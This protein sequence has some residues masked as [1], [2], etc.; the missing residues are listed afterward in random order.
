MALETTRTST[1]SSSV[2]TGFFKNGDDAHKAIN[3]LLDEG[4]RTSE[5]GAVFHTTGSYDSGAGPT[6]A[7]DIRTEGSPGTVG[8]GSGISGAASDTSGVTPAGLSTGSG[9]TTAG[10][11]RPMPSG[12]LKHT[13][14]PSELSHETARSA[15]GAIPATGGLHEQPRARTGTHS[16]G[17][18]EKLKNTFSSSEPPPA[19]ESL[20]NKTSMNFGTGEGHLGAVQPEY[21]YDYSGSAFESSFSGMGVGQERSRYLASELAGGGAVITI[22]AAGKAASAE[23]V[24]ER[25]HGSVRH[26]A[27]ISGNAGW[28]E[29]NANRVHVFG[30][31]QRSYPSFL[32]KQADAT[33]RKAS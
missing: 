28:P 24:I 4:F 12:E 22:N 15:P 33:T 26:T 6:G 29:G 8:S 23:R 9:T 5:I 16:G 7:K 18:L 10:A 25:N 1:E 2:V 21:E 20:V 31:V 30:S 14:L 32:G 17:W 19:G 27:P 11:G 13:G 3:E